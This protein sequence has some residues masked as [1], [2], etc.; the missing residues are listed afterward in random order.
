MLLAGGVGA[1]R[2]A[3]MPPDTSVAPACPARPAAASRWQDRREPRRCCCVVDQKRPVKSGTPTAGGSPRAAAGVSLH[4]G[5]GRNASARS[6]PTA[7][8]PATSCVTVV[9]MFV[10]TRMMPPTTAPAPTKNVVQPAASMPE[11]PEVPVLD[12]SDPVSPKI[13][14]KY[15]A[16][17]PTGMAMHPMTNQG[18]DAPCTD[19]VSCWPPSLAESLN[20]LD[21]F[22]PG[23]S[24]R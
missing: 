20:E 22:M 7:A 9:L 13:S 24:T 21:C 3:Q 16:I 10:T 4:V 14:P 17:P 5:R 11:P 23:A 19:T 15:A 6:A 12:T 2:S 8:P 18:V 1:R